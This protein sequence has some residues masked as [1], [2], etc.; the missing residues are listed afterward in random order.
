MNALHFSL[1]L[2]PYRSGGLTKYATDLIVA[3]REIG[4]KVS[5]LYPGDF[6]F[7]KKPKMSIKKE[8]SFYDIPVYEIENPPLVP[9]LHGVKNP[10]HIYAYP[11]M[12]IGSISS[13]YDDIK[14]D[15]FHVHTLM[16][17]P[18]E[19]IDFLKE[20]GVK[21]LFS[22]HDY[23]GLC[24]KVNFIN[25]DNKLC[26]GANPALCAACNKNAP[27]KLFLQLRNSKYLLKYKSKLPHHIYINN[28]SDADK[29]ELGVT[30][31]EVEKYKRLL[32]YYKDTFLKFDYFHFN[33]QVSEQV[34]KSCLD[35]QHSV[36]IPISN[37]NIRDNRKRKKFDTQKISIGFIGSINY[38][39]GFPLLKK[40]LIELYNEGLQNWELK[41]WGAGEGLD[42]DCELIKF[43]G[44]YSADKLLVVFDQMDLLVVPSVWKETFSFT[45]LEALSFGVPVLVTENVGAKGIVNDYSADFVIPVNEVA[46]KKKLRVI[47]SDNAD[48]LRSYNEEILKRS[49][50]YDMKYH[51][52]EIDNLYHKLLKSK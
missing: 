36:V 50:N 9:L 1:G 48:N 43:N 4:L 35:I 31:S 22:T 25:Q 15:I 16:G 23:Y 13:L 7:W 47:L 18:V 44:R 2:P 34:F 41:V 37:N 6:T 30:Q 3:Q 27:G 11:N 19:I 33:S 5:L 49:F 40:V 24:P 26:P 14:P 29:Q 38:Y 39:K 21:I 51:A 20:K 10:E 42:R 12:Y 52:D 8:K 46:L 17:L 28:S 32:E 45:T